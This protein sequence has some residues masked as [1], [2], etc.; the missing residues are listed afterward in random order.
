MNDKISYHYGSSYIN[1]AIITGIYRMLV[2]KLVRKHDKTLKD[3]R[4][5]PAKYWYLRT[6]DC[7]K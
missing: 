1:V 7:D 4:N 5:I 6:Q 3:L 2:K